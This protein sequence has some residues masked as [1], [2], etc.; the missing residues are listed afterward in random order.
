MPWGELIRSW[1][2]KFRGISLPQDSDR[3][4]KNGLGREEGRRKMGKNQHTW[5]LNPNRWLRQHLNSF[6][7]ETWK[8]CIVT[9]DYTCMENRGRIIDIHTRTLIILV[10]LQWSRFAYNH[11]DTEHFKLQ[12]Y[13]CRSL[14]PAPQD[15]HS[16]WNK[17]S[18]YWYFQELNEWFI[19]HK[20]LRII[21]FHK[22]VSA[23]HLSFFYGKIHWS[24]LFSFWWLG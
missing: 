1:K 5:Y 13:G 16:I 18:R 9:C 21:H 14:P 3:R 23:I 6:F 4:M 8:V 12:N 19:A 22:L 20:I 17:E 15:S 2:T 10:S 24:R 11:K 7:S